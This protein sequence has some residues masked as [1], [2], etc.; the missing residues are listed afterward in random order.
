M[1]LLVYPFDS[2]LLTRMLLFVNHYLFYV[3]LCDFLF[4]ESVYGCCCC[5]RR[6]R[7][8]VMICCVKMVCVF[9]CFV[10]TTNMMQPNAFVR[11]FT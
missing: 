3:V 5:R 1:S 7:V 11:A 10:R 4:F 6:C 8:V 2:G 9:V